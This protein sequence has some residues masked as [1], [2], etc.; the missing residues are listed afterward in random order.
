MR[1]KVFLAL[2]C[3]SVALA[4]PAALRADSCTGSGNLVTNCSFGTGDLTGWNFT[5]AGSGTDFYIGVGSGYN[6][7][8][9]ANFGAVSDEY[10]TISQTLTT[11]S[12]QTYT[13]TFWLSNEYGDNTGVS[14]DFQA[15]WN[16]TSLLEQYTTSGLIEYTYIVT[17]TGSDTLTFEGYNGPSWYLLSDVSVSNTSPIPEPSSLL[18][19]GS[20]LAVLAGL[21]RRRFM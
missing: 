10:D 21:M 16:G 15:L 17:G 3:L 11:V 20:G 6:G 7:D 9:S 19:L 1:V 12:G 13:L 8:N 14:T 5:A 4:L 2:G 18:L